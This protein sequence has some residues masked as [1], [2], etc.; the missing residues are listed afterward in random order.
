MTLLPE[1]FGIDPGFLSRYIA[2]INRHG[3]GGGGYSLRALLSDLLAIL[4][5]RAVALME[6]DLICGPSSKAVKVRSGIGDMEWASSVIGSEDCRKRLR[7]AVQ[8]H[9]STGRTF[10][11]GEG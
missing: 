5:C 2:L 3:A 7:E 1:T 9:D 10:V 6:L 4:G 11:L 8:V